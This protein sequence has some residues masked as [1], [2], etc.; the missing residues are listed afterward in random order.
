LHCLLWFFPEQTNKPPNERNFIIDLGEVE[1]W[2][3]VG[4]KVRGPL[5]AKF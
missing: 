4:G 5:I 1:T 2:E 3:A